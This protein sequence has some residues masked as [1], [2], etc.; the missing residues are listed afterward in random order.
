V[1]ADSPLTVVLSSLGLAAGMA[2]LIVALLSRR[3]VG[4]DSSALVLA[5][6]EKLRR[7]QEDAAQAI[8]WKKLAAQ[9]AHVG[10][11]HLALPS[12]A[13]TWS[14]EVYRIYGVEPG[15]FQ[16][17]VEN[18]IV[19]YHPDD[20]PIVRAA[21]DRAIV[22]GQDFDIPVRLV[23]ASGEIRHVVSRGIAR[24]G[25]NGKVEAIFG[26]FLDLTEQKAIEAQLREAKARAETLMRQDSLT[27]LAN[28]RHFDLELATATA[29]AMDNGTPLGLI[30]I[31]VDHFKA[32]NDH[33]GHL[34]GDACLQRVAGLVSACADRPG[35][36]VA[37]FGGEEIAVLLPG[38]GMEGADAVAQRIVR[39]VRDAEIPHAGV[40]SGYV[41]VSTGVESCVPESTLRDGREIVHRADIALYSAKRAGRDRSMRYTR[42]TL[43]TMGSVSARQA[44]G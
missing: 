11:W 21:L 26:V 8:Q 14:D 10:H 29:Q 7:A 43:E 35:D 1:Y 9:I 33:Y 24:F 32:Y 28:R 25:A 37:R 41:T 3:H 44:V 39:L 17:T 30:M 40:P 18:A 36:L 16:P 22:T 31:D 13:C 34:E 12:M 6:T 19:G 2:A 15:S 5:L 38:T 23:R 20:Q 42:P 27:G 4:A